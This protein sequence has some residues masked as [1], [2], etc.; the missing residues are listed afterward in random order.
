MGR[1]SFGTLNRDIFGHAVKL[2]R[3]VRCWRRGR[4]VFRA[5]IIFNMWA[6]F[7]IYLEK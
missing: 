2:E 6:I 4:L 5:D 3:F 1:F 7:P